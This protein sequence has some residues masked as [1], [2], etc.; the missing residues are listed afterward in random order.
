MTEEDR[1]GLAELLQLIQ[2]GEVEAVFVVKPDRLYRD[3]T[4][5]GPIDFALLCQQHDVY[6]VYIDYRGPA[7]I[8]FNNDEGFED[9]IKMS[10]ESA[11][12]LKNMQVRMGGARY[13]KAKSGKY[14]GGMLHWGWRYDVQED[15][16]VLYEPHRQTVL[17]IARAA[18]NCR[19]LIQTLRHV[20]Q[21]PTC[22][23]QPF[24]GE[25]LLTTYKRHTVRQTNVSVDQ[26]YVPQSI[27]Q[28]GV[29]LTWP[30]NVGIRT[31][32]SGKHGQYEIFA[33]ARKQ[34]RGKVRSGI[35]V[36]PLFL[37]VDPELALFRTPEEQEL[38]WQI[39]E[40]FNPIDLR[41]SLETK[42]KKERPNPNCA[43]PRRGKPSK[44]L[45]NAYAGLV[46]CRLHGVDESGDF[47]LTHAL[48]IQK[49]GHECWTCSKD[50]DFG[51][52]KKFC[53]NI[54]RRVVD[55]VLDTQVRL[56]LSGGQ[57]FVDDLVRLIEEREKEEGA[58]QAMLRQKF[59]N[60][61][62][63]IGNYTAQ[64]K[65]ID[66]RTEVGKYL[67]NE[68]QE[69]LAPLLDEKQIIEE[70]LAREKTV[71]DR[72]PSSEDVITVRDALVR[73]AGKWNRVEPVIRNKLLRLIIENI[74]IYAVPGKRT[75]FMRFR[76]RD[77]T[78]DWLMFWYWGQRNNEP[79]AEWEK[80]ALRRM[81]GDEN[82]T[83]ARKIL[84]AL[85]PGRKWRTVRAYAR[86]LGLNA[87]VYRSD[88][89]ELFIE[90]DK[91]KVPT[92]D[93]E[94]LVYYHLGRVPRGELPTAKEAQEVYEKD[95]KIWLGKMVS[96]QITV[97]LLL[98]RF[99]SINVPTV[100]ST[101]TPDWTIWFLPMLRP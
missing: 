28:I 29:I 71:L 25:D 91:E 54:R 36:R 51:N 90:Q 3:Q 27:Y 44:G 53:A 85:R 93:D 78:D 70:R 47:L 15:R 23:F 5:V 2:R 72:S 34:K 48:R 33:K 59:A 100:I 7:I 31:F 60:L 6:V 80:D 87:A 45:R 98:F 49:G 19:S 16:I 35:R 8:D 46:R 65:D 17:N 75:I 66:V 30:L 81:W 41:Y 26:P 12:E 37:G 86:K 67:F 50:H 11:R 84:S 20:K 61:Q 74:V 57:Q 43:N 10:Q 4:L 14:A 58:N 9:W 39:Q 79:W 52:S 73:V 94:T 1:P 77:S 13:Y 76:W 42:F 64:L 96:E 88:A 32:G 97:F 18:V 69:R 24:Q 92:D 56:R 62:Q 55:R 22:W 83:L 89:D 82:E 101:L 68:L 38:F 95:G 40:C 21:D 99:A 63:A